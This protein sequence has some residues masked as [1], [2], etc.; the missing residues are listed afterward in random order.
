MTITKDDYQAFSEF[1]KAAWVKLPEHYDTIVGPMTR[2]AV[3]AVLDSVALRPGM[4]LL[5]VA[6]GL[7]YVAAEAQR[8]GAEA[9]G[10]D[11]SL[12]MINE[13]RRHFPDLKIDQ[14]DA[15]NLDYDD[16]S[17]DAVTCA[18]GMLHFP[19]PGKALAE[20]YRVLRPGG[21]FAFTVWVA[22]P[23][24]KF[25]GTIGDTVIKYSDMSAAPPKGPSSYMLSDSM[26]CAALMDAGTFAD[27]EVVEVPCD[28]ELRAPGDMLEFMKK[29]AVR[30]VYI[31]ERQ[32]PAV[33]A[34]IEQALLDEA[35]KLIAQG[36][37]KVP[38]PIMLVSGTKA[39]E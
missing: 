33:Q 38:C 31:F 4:A 24:N 34:L 10:L 9:T 32:T 39:A 18:F 12:D 5:D 22:P 6:S 15:E 25:F 14:G 35:A 21:R 11:F 29:C 8:R 30:P 36:Q 20:A 26:V 23:K 3:E 2:R 1:E 28:F 17:F 37:S 13:A 16:A 19:R 7:G 27:V